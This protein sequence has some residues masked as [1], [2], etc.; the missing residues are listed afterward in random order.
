MS[1]KLVG[2]ADSQ[3]SSYIQNQLQS[4]ADDIS[5]LQTELA[6]ESDSRLQRYCK[7]PNRMPC[8]MVFKNDVY[9]KHV[10]AKFNATEALAWV[11]GA[12]G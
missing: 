1:H 4:I 9:L 5:G 11:R 3:T 7:K 2:F 8:L 10:H 6:N 12:I